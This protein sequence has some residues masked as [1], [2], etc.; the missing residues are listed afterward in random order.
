MRAFIIIQGA[1]ADKTV[2]EWGDTAETLG[3]RGQPIGTFNSATFAVNAPYFI[4]KNIT[5]K[6]SNTDNNNSPVPAPNPITLVLLCSHRTPPLFHDQ[7]RGGS[8][9]WR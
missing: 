2:V 4:A 6:V 1:G 8:K 9:R 7:G 5:F 3:P